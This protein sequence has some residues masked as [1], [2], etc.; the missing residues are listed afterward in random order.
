MAGLDSWMRAL[1]ELA[2]VPSRAAAPVAAKLQEQIDR[3]FAEGVDPYGKRWAA[4]AD[5]DPSYLTRSTDLHQS[6]VVR[7]LPGAGVAITVGAPYGQFHQEGTSR[8]PARPI[9]P[10]AGLPPSWA[11][12]VSAGVEEAYRKG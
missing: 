12:A 5:G 1:E 6:V 11:E 4:K 9:L 3:Q 7:P 10:T 2:R 8:M